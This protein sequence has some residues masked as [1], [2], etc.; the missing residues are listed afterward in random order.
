MVDRAGGTVRFEVDS[1][2]VDAGALGIDRACFAIA[3]GGL[4]HALEFRRDEGFGGGGATAAG[5]NLD[6]DDI[7]SVGRDDVDFDA[8]DAYV[9]FDEAHADGLE[10]VCSDA[11]AEITEPPAGSHHLKVYWAT[12][13]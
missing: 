12:G 7:V 6:E 3:D 10:A 1:D 9:P 2:N 13:A 11:F 4:P 8:T 5:P